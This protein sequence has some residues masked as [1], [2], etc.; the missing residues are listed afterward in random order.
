LQHLNLRITPLCAFTII[1]L[2]IA[3]FFCVKNV[4][5]MLFQN[6]CDMAEAGLVTA[7]STAG[8]LVFL[9]AICIGARARRGKKVLTAK[10]E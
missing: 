2:I 9:A 6:G 3:F 10:A 8:I 5:K 7:V 1:F 4:N